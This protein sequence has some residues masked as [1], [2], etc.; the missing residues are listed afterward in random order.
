MFDEVLILTFL[1]QV[2]WCELKVAVVWH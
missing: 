2:L 1:C